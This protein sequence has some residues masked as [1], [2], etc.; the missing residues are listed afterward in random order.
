MTPTRS[1]FLEPLLQACQD[2]D[3][4]AIQ[5]YVAFFE[6]DHPDLKAVF[7]DV[8]LALANADEAHWASPKGHSDLDSPGVIGRKALRKLMTPET[9]TPL[10]MLI[11]HISHTDRLKA[12]ELLRGRESPESLRRCVEILYGVNFIYDRIIGA[13]NDDIAILSELGDAAAGAADSLVLRLSWLGGQA[14]KWTE[15]ALFDEEHAVLTAL[16]RFKSLPPSTFPVLIEVAQRERKGH[17][18]NA[19][20]ELNSLA[21]KA[22]SLIKPPPCWAIPELQKIVQTPKDDLFE[23]LFFELIEGYILSLIRRLAVIHCFD[24]QSHAYIRNIKALYLFGVMYREGFRS[25]REISRELKNRYD[26]DLAKHDIDLTFQWQ[27]TL[28]TDRLFVDH[29]ASVLNIN[30]FEIFTSENG[31]GFAMVFTTDA[32]LAWHWAEAFLARQM[33][34]DWFGFATPKKPSQE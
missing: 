30:R 17:W 27:K 14:D 28:L 13:S 2:D 34:P 26:A 9:P 22:I 18:H 25:I 23:G 12:V 31:R 15:S 10:V 16:T 8:I 24:V 11:G 33:P 20:D 1:K 5:R 6:S 4:A 3:R 7:R 19:L 32:W 29:M 21:F